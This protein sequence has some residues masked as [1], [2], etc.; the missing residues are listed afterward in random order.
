MKVPNGPHNL[1]G[2]G[3][4]ATFNATPLGGTTKFDVF[5]YDAD[6]DLYVGPKTKVVIEFHADGTFFYWWENAAPPI[7][8]SGI[9][10][11]I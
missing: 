6:R 5:T 9:G 7:P 3:A 1:T 4:A 11:W 10:T 8:P 2:G